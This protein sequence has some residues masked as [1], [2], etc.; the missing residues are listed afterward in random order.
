MWRLVLRSYHE[1][2]RPSWGV[3]AY[4]RPS[5]IEL[6]PGSHAMNIYHLL[7]RGKLEILLPGPGRWLL[8]EAVDSETS[9]IER[10]I[11]RRSRGEDG[12]SVTTCWPWGTR[13]AAS[14][15]RRLPTKPLETKLSLTIH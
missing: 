7:L 5:R 10:R 15:W 9:P 13:P 11:R 12:K 2:S 3:Q 4:A 6:G 14:D 8:H 1:V